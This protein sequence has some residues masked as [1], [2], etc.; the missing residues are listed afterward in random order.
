MET[1]M[2]NTPKLVVLVKTGREG[3]RFDP[4]S[5]TEYKATMPSTSFEI[6]RG[7]AFWVRTNGGPKI[8]ITGRNYDDDERF[9]DNVFRY[10]TGYTLRQLIRFHDSAKARCI[11]G[12][13]HNTI[14]MGGYCGETF[15]VCT[16]CNRVVDSFFDR[17]SIA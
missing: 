3:P 8:N 10:A 1:T 6:H 14:S 13:R 5:Y 15:D 17:E 11:E 4:Y 9:V 2:I 16:K 7:L 12:G